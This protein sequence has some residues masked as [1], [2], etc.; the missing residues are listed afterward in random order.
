ME[1]MYQSLTKH[2]ECESKLYNQMSSI[3]TSFDQTFENSNSFWTESQRRYSEACQA[4]ASSVSASSRSGASAI[5]IAGA[6][7]SSDSSSGSSCSSASASCT[8]V[9]FQFD[10][11]Q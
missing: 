10:Q 7:S 6:S 4:F 1:S 9:S 5:A 11:F 2:C 3:V 8:A